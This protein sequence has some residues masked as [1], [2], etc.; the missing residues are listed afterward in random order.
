MVKVKVRFLFNV[1][2]LAAN[3]YFLMAKGRVRPP[4]NFV[5]Q[6]I[7]CVKKGVLWRAENIVS[8]SHHTTW[9]TSQPTVVRV[10]PVTKD[11]K[12]NTL[13]VAPSRPARRMLWNGHVKRRGWERDD[14]ERRGS[15]G[16]RS[17]RRWGKKTWDSSNEELWHIVMAGRTFC[18]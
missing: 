2:L 12:A 11:T 15:L 10:E 8:T 13:F 1:G 6:H 16:A 14:E 5:D 3:G 17:S 9:F 18:G 7:L 4:R